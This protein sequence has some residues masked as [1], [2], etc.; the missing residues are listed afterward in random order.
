MEGM[1]PAPFAERR[2]FVGQCLLKSLDLGGQSLCSNSFRTQTDVC[3]GLLERKLNLHQG[4]FI[5]RMTTRENMSTP[6]GETRV[7]GYIGKEVICRNMNTVE[8]R[9]TDIQ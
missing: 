1:T 5:T 8:L 6:Q 4:R 7:S 2:F 3:S 9:I